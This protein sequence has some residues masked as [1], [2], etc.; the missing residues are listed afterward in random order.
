MLRQVGVQVPSK[1]QWLEFKF[2]WGVVCRHQPALHVQC[3]FAAAQARGKVG[4][5]QLSP[6]LPVMVV[7]TAPLCGT[8]HWQLFTLLLSAWG[9]VVERLRTSQLCRSPH[10]LTHPRHG[11]DH[12]VHLVLPCGALLTL[13]QHTRARR[14][15]LRR[16]GPKPYSVEYAKSGRAGCKGCK[17]KIG[18]DTLR[19]ARMVKS[20]HVRSLPPVTP[21]SA[22]PPV[23]VGR[24]LAHPLP[25]HMGP[26]SLTASCRSGTITDA[27]GT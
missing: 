16:D 25:V 20:P 22:V 12:A 18:Q 21:L 7:I 24:L 5:R 27:S 4:A 13:S 10:S 15:L 19:V 8:I 14:V 3:R 17:A 2:G 6:A 1:V 11:Q 26:G 23:L 9:D